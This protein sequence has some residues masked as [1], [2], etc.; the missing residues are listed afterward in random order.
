M[1]RI[2]SR[3]VAGAVLGT[4]FLMAAGCE[5]GETPPAR[6]GP[7]EAPAAPSPP[8][9]DPPPSSTP[10]GRTVV[11]QVTGMMKSKAGAT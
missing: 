7:T 3:V 11:L 1:K 5:G 8:E 2:M 6:E 4:I 9:V 10:T